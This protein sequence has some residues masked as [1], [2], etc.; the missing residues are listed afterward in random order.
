MHIYKRGKL[1]IFVILF[2]LSNIYSCLYYSVCY[3]DFVEDIVF[4]LYKEG[5]YFPY[6]NPNYMFIS[7]A[8][9]FAKERTEYTNDNDFIVLCLITDYDKT[10]YKVMFG[11][12]D[13]NKYPD[14]IEAYSYG[15]ELVMKENG[16][17]FFDNVCESPMRSEWFLRKG[18]Y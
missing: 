5:E 15:Y 4:P 12:F 9:K 10:H 8:I 11:L 2:L 17:W 13:N 16:N 6:N 14:K 1:T 7:S 18:T 3:A